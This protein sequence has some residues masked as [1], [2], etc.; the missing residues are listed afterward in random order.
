MMDQAS[1]YPLQLP[2]DAKEKLQLVSE[3]EELL[4]DL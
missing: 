3:L 2:D 4:L 1:Q